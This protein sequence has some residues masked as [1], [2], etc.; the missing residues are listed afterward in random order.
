MISDDSV[1]ACAAYITFDA[2]LAVCIAVFHAAIALWRSGGG[3][4]AGVASPFGFCGT[5]GT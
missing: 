1:A 2:L 4:G 5:G 3:L